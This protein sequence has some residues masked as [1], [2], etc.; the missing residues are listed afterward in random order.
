MYDHMIW[1]HQFDPKTSA[2]YALNA[3]YNVSVSQ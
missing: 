1:P 3:R 2:I